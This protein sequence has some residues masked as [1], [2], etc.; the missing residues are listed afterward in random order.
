MKQDLQSHAK[1]TLNSYKYRLYMP[2]T[3]LLF[4]FKLKKNFIF[5][6]IFFHSI[7]NDDN[8]FLVVELVECED[9][10]SEQLPDINCTAWTITPI[11][12]LNKPLTDYGNADISE[13]INR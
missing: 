11:S 9:P 6:T 10:Y 7:V 1:F 3:K 13:C 4:K 8:I 2:K 5:Q 12:S